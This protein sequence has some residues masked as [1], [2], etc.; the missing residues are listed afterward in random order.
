[1]GKQ[2]QTSTIVKDNPTLQ[3]KVSKASRI[4]QTIYC[5]VSFCLNNIFIFHSSR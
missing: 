4:S 2:V 3:S 1:M 5:V